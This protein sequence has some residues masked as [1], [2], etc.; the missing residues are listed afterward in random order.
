MSENIGVKVRIYVQYNRYYI[1]SD[2]DNSHVM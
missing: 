1:Q 2:T